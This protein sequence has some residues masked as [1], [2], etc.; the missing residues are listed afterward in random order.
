[1]VISII[2]ERVEIPHD[3]T[4]SVVYIN[5]PKLYIEKFINSTKEAKES[6]YILGKNIVLPDNIAKE[7]E[8]ANKR[9]VELHI[10]AENCSEIKGFTLKSYDFSKSF[11]NGIS[12]SL[13]IFDNNSVLIPSMELDDQSHETALYFEDAPSLIKD[14]HNFY[15]LGRYFGKGNTVKGSWPNSLLVKYNYKNPHKF[16]VNS[17]SGEIGNISFAQ[18]GTIVPPVR[19]SHY[20]PMKT[21]IRETPSNE[22]LVSTK[23]FVQNMSYTPHFTLQNQLIRVATKDYNKTVKI[24][25]SRKDPYFNETLVWLSSITSMKNISARITNESYIPNYVVAGD[26]FIFSTYPLSDILFD[27]SF[28]YT[29]LGRNFGNITKQFK[30]EFYEKFEKAQTFTDFVKYINFTENL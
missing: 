2:F 25:V 10:I 18:C 28:G 3:S 29:V 13:I 12:S 19:D 17:T 4:K 9:G 1:M 11:P 30:E 8:D 20:E 7:L 22:I 24:L 6:I 26:D 5:D 15:S 14:L 21:I 23:R 16:I 27:R